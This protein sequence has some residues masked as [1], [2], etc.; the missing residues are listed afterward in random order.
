MIQ[1]QL[2]ECLSTL[3]IAIVVAHHHQVIIIL[4]TPVI[5][6]LDSVQRVS[7]ICEHGLYLLLQLLGGGTVQVV[8]EPSS[9]PLDNIELSS[10]TNMAYDD[11]DTMLLVK[12]YLTCSSC[13]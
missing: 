10:Y 7:I 4:G 8:R 2:E 6:E 9:Q 5:I 1:T 11:E 3:D 13:Q 12:T